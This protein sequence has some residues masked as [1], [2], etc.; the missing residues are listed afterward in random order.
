MFIVLYYFMPVPVAA[1][2]KAWFCGH[3]LAGIAGSNPTLVSVVQVVVCASGWSFV[4][5]NPTDYGV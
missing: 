1:R 5:R 4:Q 2:S 3:T